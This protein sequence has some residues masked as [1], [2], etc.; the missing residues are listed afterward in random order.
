MKIYVNL[1]VHT[2]FVLENL[3][4]TIRIFSFSKK[5]EMSVSYQIYYLKCF[6]CLCV[7]LI[8]VFMLLVMQLCEFSTTAVRD[9]RY[10]IKYTYY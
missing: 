7:Y 8:L 2:I 4:L 5:K 1:N 9:P 6:T 10:N 3:F